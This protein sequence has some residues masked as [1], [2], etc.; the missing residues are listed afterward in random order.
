MSHN[1]LII[2]FANTAADRRQRHAVEASN[3]HG[4]RLIT[5][6]TD[7]LLG[8]VT[9]PLLQLLTHTTGLLSCSHSHMQIL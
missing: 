4:R 9:V 5:P 7:I 6:P 8:K 1:L 3:V 2:V